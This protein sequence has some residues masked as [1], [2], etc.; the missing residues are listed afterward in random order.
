MADDAA[1]ADRELGESSTGTDADAPAEDSDDARSRTPL[2]ADRLAPVIGLVVVVALAGVAGWLG[3]R[4]YESHQADQQ[5]RLFVQVGRQA[6]VNLATIDFHQADA[7]V[8]RILDGATGQFYDNFSQRSQPFIDVLVRAQSQSVGTVTEA[9][10]ESHSGDEA[11]VL[12]SVT[13][14]TSNAGAP[15]QEP[16]LWRMRLSVQKVGDE[17]KVSNVDFVQ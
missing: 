1:A 10:L 5:R 8:Q 11:Q 4:A 13:V 3:F 2:S 12:V 14:R 15:E 6:A 7:D 17:A 16:R 9:G